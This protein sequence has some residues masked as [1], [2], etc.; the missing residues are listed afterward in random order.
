MA[1]RLKR[2]DPI[3]RAIS[4]LDQQIAALQRQMRETANPPMRAGEARPVAPNTAA[5]A[6]SAAQTVA[7]FLKDMLTTSKRATGPSYH[8]RQDLFDVTADPLKDLEAEP[9]AFARKP[10]PDLFAN[11]PA[12]GNVVAAGTSALETAQVVPP[13]E[14]LAHYL[15][16]GSIKSYK[17]LRRVQRQTRNRFFMW[18]GLAFVALWIILFVIR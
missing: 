8:A 5:S 16:A 13:Q 4:D 11:A 12:P 6:R 17:P 1:F 2:A 10:E 7:Q 9:I 18:V 14:K 15:G 3:N